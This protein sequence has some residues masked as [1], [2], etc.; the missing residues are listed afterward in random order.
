LVDETTIAATGIKG[1]NS[2]ASTSDFAQFVIDERE[3]DMSFSI[4]ELF[5]KIRRLILCLIAA[6]K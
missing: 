3:T 4:F 2:E 6:H 5:P 1:K